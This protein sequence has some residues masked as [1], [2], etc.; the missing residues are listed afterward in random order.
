MYYPMYHTRYVIPIIIT[1]VNS[2]MSV[3]IYPYDDYGG[4]KGCCVSCG[5]TWC[6]DLEEC[7]RVWE[8]YCKSL[9]N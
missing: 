6:P 4:D 2:V 9:E 7:V 1:L 8:T 3:P 5:Y